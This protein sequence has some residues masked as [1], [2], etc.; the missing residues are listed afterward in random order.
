MSM[1]E[2][3]VHLY[4]DTLQLAGF[5]IVQ[6]LIMCKFTHLPQCIITHSDTFLLSEFL[7]AILKP[8]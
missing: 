2:G 6:P 3:T 8:F 1:T 5:F 7:F 4:A